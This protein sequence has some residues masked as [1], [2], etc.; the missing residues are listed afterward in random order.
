MPPLFRKFMKQEKQAKKEK[1]SSKPEKITA[2]ESLRRV[3]SF[4]E[5]KE[6]IIAFIIKSEN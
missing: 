5:R 6:K 3:K 4:T 2:A 1:T